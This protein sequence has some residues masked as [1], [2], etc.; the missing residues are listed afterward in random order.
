MTITRNK[1]P[2]QVVKQE[3]V[4]IEANLIQEEMK[5]SN[6]IPV[7]DKV[8]FSVEESR[9]KRKEE[10]K[11]D[12]LSVTSIGPLLLSNEQSLCRHGGGNVLIF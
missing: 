5:E 12:E 11:I 9:R 4:A 7:A 1:N 8:S 6:K 2:L 10:E 3:K